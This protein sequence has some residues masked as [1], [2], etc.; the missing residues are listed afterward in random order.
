MAL[1]THDFQTPGHL[2]RC[3]DSKAKTEVKCPWRV[4]GAM[5]DVLL[6][7]CVFT[8]NVKCM[9]KASTLFSAKAKMSYSLL[10]V[11]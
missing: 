8:I 9:V 10:T 3:V 5:V 6:Y 1:K 4:R 11:T 7:F 2:G